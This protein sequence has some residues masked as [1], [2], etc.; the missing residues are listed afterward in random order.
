MLRPPPRSTLFPYTTLFRSERPDEQRQERSPES[1]ALRM[2]EVRAQE[3]GEVARQQIPLEVSEESAPPV[4]RR[5]HRAA[6]R[7]APA[8]ARSLVPRDGLRV[9]R[10]SPPRSRKAQREVDVFVVGEEAVVEEVAVPRDVG[11]SLPTKEHGGRGDA[12]DF[13]RG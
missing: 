12:R 1:E 5:P 6:E 2:S 8:G 7:G 11:E 4:S 9:A 13:E 3:P 10:E